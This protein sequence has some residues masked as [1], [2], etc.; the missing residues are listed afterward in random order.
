VT[1]FISSEASHKLLDLRANSQ[2]EQL[3]LTV[4]GREI[5][6]QPLTLGE[7]Q[8]VV[9]GNLPMHVIHEWAINRCVLYNKE[10]LL[11]DAPAGY[12][13]QIFEAILENSTVKKQAE[14]LTLIEASRHFAE[15]LQGGIESLICAAFPT[16][17]PRSVRGLTQKEQFKYLAMAETI[18]D[19]RLDTDAIFG[20]KPGK[21]SRP[22]VTV[23]FRDGYQSTDLSAAEILAEHNADVPDFTK[24]NSQLEN[25]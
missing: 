3:F 11:T 5:I 6:F 17:T 19:R 18:L 2:G 13:Q 20:K 24:D 9:D 23:P 21:P 8:A 15:T 7:A 12:T 22:G 14:V 16:I 4:L 1:I 10:W 25:F